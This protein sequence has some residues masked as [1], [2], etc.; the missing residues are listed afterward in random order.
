MRMG[1]ALPA[2]PHSIALNRLEVVGS[3]APMIRSSEQQ[4]QVEIVTT[5]QQA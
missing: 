1:F 5:S 3:T 2:R 4:V